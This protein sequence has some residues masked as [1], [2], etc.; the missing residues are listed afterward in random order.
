MM[1][2][3]MLYLFLVIEVCLPVFLFCMDNDFVIERQDTVWNKQNDKFNAYITE[4]V[5]FS[6]PTKEIVKWK[7]KLNECH[8]TILYG[9]LMALS[10]IQKKFCPNKKIW[11]ESMNIANE[12]KKTASDGSGMRK[13][14]NQSAILIAQSAGLPKDFLY[15][16]CKQAERTDVDLSFI[17]MSKI[18]LKD[19]DSLLLRCA[20][21]D[22]DIDTEITKSNKEKKSISIIEDKIISGAIAINHRFVENQYVW[23]KEALCIYIIAFMEQKFSLIYTAIEIFEKRYYSD[24]SYAR[25]T[26]S[27]EYKQLQTMHKRMC[28]LL[29][30]LKGK[31]EA[32]IMKN[33]HD[34]YN[35]H[36]KFGDFHYELL[37][38]INRYWK[39]IAW[40]EKYC[41][42]S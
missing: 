17:K 21:L 14:K 31:R 28:S 1:I 22:Y 34:T 3:K 7:G 30:A 12:L 23:F 6:N 29:P 10:R 16:L 9:S 18:P 13:R 5:P 39:I 42:S 8:N 11:E 37:C 24:T 38:K 27:E 26:E 40:L 36:E 25:P 20:M 41:L 19:S 2:H 32:K 15:M 35:M 4:G 33:F